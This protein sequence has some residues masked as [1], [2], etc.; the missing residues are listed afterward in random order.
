[1]VK[2]YSIDREQDTIRLAGR[3]APLLGKGVVW[4][5]YGELGT[6]K[7]FFT[8]HLCQSL[9]VDEPVTSPSFVLINQYEAPQF[10][11]YHVDLY[12][13]QSEEEVWSLGLEEIIEEGAVVIEW[14]QLA[15]RLFNEQT[16]RF[17]FEYERG[18]RSVSIEGDEHILQQID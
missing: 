16:I 10:T 7:T 15:E 11:I 17:Y 6:G 8:R 1:M 9:G 3:V 13:L 5:L 18:T 2:K 4:A 12:R 14:P